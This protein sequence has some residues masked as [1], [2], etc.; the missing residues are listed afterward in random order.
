MLA[1]FIVLL[2]VLI[3][4]GIGVLIILF[5]GLVA[6]TPLILIGGLSVVGASAYY[7]FRR[8]KAQRKKP[9]RNSEFTTVQRKIHRNQLSGRYGLHQNRFKRERHNSTGHRVRGYPSPP[10]G[11]RNRNGFETL[12]ILPVH[13]KK[14]TSIKKQPK[15]PEG[16]FSIEQTV[17]RTPFRWRFFGT[18]CF[19]GKRQ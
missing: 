6:Y 15:R 16:I 14:T 13:L 8:F 12:W 1:Y 18:P 5:R 17:H 3:V 10:G 7:L 2:H 19:P 9:E 11:P 4:A